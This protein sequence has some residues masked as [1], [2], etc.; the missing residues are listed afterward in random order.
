VN[1]TGAG[2]TD[3]GV[4]ASG[5]VVAFDISWQHPAA[6]LLRAINVNLPVDIALQAVDEV[7]LDF[8]PRFDA[9]GRQ[10]VYRLYHSN[11][12]DPLRDRYSWQIAKSLD[13]SV[14]QQAA[15]HLPGERDFSAFGTPPQGNNP[16]R[17]IYAADWNEVDRGRYT[18]TISANAF[19]YR[20]VRRIVGTLVHI[21]QRFITPAEF[22]QIIRSGDSSKVLLA[23]PHGLTLTS[24]WYENLPGIRETL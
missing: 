6:A 7:A 17:A 22:E 19:L 11:I 18:F 21:G 15:G 12:R 20:M 2:R 24:V 9:L 5:Q 16:V 14:I 13:S 4:H 3:A 23:P 10:Y 1:V 8:H